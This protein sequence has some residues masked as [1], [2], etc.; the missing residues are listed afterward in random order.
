MT[1]KIHNWLFNQGFTFVRSEGFPLQNGQSLKI[2]SGLVKPLL[3][4]SNANQKKLNDGVDQIRSLIVHA[5]TQGKR[6]NA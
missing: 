6:T 1:V 5:F 3:A 4:W 2:F